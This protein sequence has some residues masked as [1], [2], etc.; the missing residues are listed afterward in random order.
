MHSLII[1]VGG[2]GK[3]VAAVYLMLS[4][5]FG[6]PSDVLILDML[7]RNEE[8]DNQ[9][10]KE[11]VK[12]ED[13]MTP[14]P[15][16]A[17]S[18]SGVRFAEIIGLTSGDVAEPVA[19]AL[20]TEDELN[21]LVE[22]GMNARPI[23]G[24]TV[25]MRK[26][27]GSQQDTQ[28]DDLRR[29]VAQYTDIFVVGSIT[30]G[31][32]SGVMPTLGQWLTEECGKPVHGI[33]FLPWIKIGAGTGDGPSDAV[34]QAN[35]HAVLSYLREVD[36]STNPARAKGPAPFRDYVVIGNPANLDPDTSA[37]SASHPL[38][39]VAATYLIYFDEILTRNPEVQS[40][41]YYL[42]ITSGGLRAS[43]MQPTRGFSLEQAI[44]RQHWFYKVLND[45]AVQKPDEAWDLPVPPLAANWLAWRALR[46][47]VR[48]LALMSEGRSA[49]HVVWKEMSNYFSKEAKEAEGRLSQFASITSRDRQHLVYNV[50]MEQLEKQAKGYERRALSKASTVNVPNFNAKL[51]WD[52]AARA[53]AE[54]ISQDIFIKLEKMAA[55]NITA[56]G[57]PQS[58]RAGSSTVFLPPGVQDPSGGINAIARKPLTNLKGLIQKYAGAIEAINMPNPQARRFQFEIILDQALTEYL[59]D[60]SRPKAK[61][62]ANESLAQFMALLEGVIFGVLQIKLFDLAS[63][64]FQ[65]SYD[66]RI[67]GVLVDKAGKVYGGTDPETLFFPAP[68]AWDQDHGALRQLSQENVTRRDMQAGQFARKLLQSFRATFKESERPLWMRAVDEYLHIYGPPTTNIDET[69]LRA[70]WKHAGPIQL[71]LPNNSVDAR[72]IPVFETDFTALA[73]NALSGDFIPRGGEIH[74]KVNNN[75]AGRIFYPDAVGNGLTLRLMGAGSI[76]ILPGARNRSATSAPQINYDQ[77]RNSCEVLIG[78]S[79]AHASDADVKADP[80][81]YP[82]VIRL[83]FQ[84]DGFLAEYFLNGGKADETYGRPFLNAVRGRGV[85][86]LPGPSNNQL[87]PTTVKEGDKTYYFID[88]NGSVY[89]ERYE[90]KEIKELSLLGQVLWTIFI[91]E[92]TQIQNRNMFVDAGGSVLLE[93]SA[94]RFMPGPQVSLNQPNEQLRAADLRCLADKINQ[95]GTDLLFKEAVACWLKYFNMSPAPGHCARSQ[96]DLSDRKWWRP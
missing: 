63:Y 14:W 69:K 4:R 20:F 37:T 17:K 19:K 48:G 35:A 68:G 82:D 11:G 87:P 53:A 84:Q 88:E 30:G 60:P 28:L 10:D 45:M 67:L 33:L 72:Y 94:Q 5:F 79:M 43:E 31:T 1:A 54:T 32:G 92:A 26:F 77:L 22:K 80:F 93:Y 71:R 83:P 13:F 42:E 38:N 2:T 58:A 6:K 66:R 74:L 56:G 18:V 65:S 27:Y 50:S 15:G 9:L 40:G 3:S 23:V 29:K 59:R 16:G 47:S 46:E 36:P 62:D 24:A 81:K 64:G 34:L 90:G 61:W 70:G 52:N 55:E 78:D 8:I 75:D 95:S 57:A 21:T 39:L 85:S 25:A 91:G 51:S 41:P 12:Q 7:F 96:F 89:V 86:A 49:R 76:N 44:N 73:I